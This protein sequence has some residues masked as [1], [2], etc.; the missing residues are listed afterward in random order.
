MVPQER[1]AI[2]K[3]GCGIRNLHSDCLGIVKS[4]RGVTASSGCQTYVFLR[5]SSPSIFTI[6]KLYSELKKDRA[7]RDCG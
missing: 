1:L 6:C 7:Y 2:L 4:G 5:K 3:M